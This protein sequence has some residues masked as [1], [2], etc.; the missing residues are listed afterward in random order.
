[1]RTFT[2]LLTACAAAAIAAGCASPAPPTGP[3]TGPT[4]PPAADDGVVRTAD[5]AVH[6]TVTAD[7]RRFQG[8]PYAAPPVGELR[9]RSPQQ[10]RPWGEVRDGTRPGAPCPQAWPGADGTPQASGSEDCLF[11]DV[12][13][14]RTAPRPLPVMVF[15]H[16]G[17]FTG[18][19]GAPYDPTRVVT[20]GDVVVV[21]LNY[22]LGALGFLAHP[23]FEDP[24]TG[25]FGLADQQA[26]LRW[27]QRNI[28]AF[29]GDPANVTL[30]G[31]SAGAFSTCAQL[32]A[33]GARGLFHKAIVQSGPC[34]NPVLA[35]EEA[36]RRAA[37]TAAELGCPGP[38][39][40]VAC[41]RALPAEA[42][43]G[44]YDEQ[45]YRQVHR[46]LAARPWLPVAGTPALP[47]HPVEALRD[48]TAADVPM[49]HGG[50][51]DEARSHVAMAYDMP[52][53]PIT[54]QQ[55]PQVVAALFGADAGA[56]L[57]EYP[58]QQYPAPGVALATAL[59]DEGRTVGACAQQ[60]VVDAAGGRVFAYEFAEPVDEVVG[61]VPMGAHHGADV[62]YFFDSAF[63]GAPPPS[64]TAEEDALATR[65]I[66]YWTAFADTGDPGPD[67][68][69][70]DGTTVL[71][72]DAAGSRPVDLAA[73]HRCAFWRSLPSAG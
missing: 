38:A 71:R 64:R 12:T 65:L 57:A 49:I 22:R 67:W 55:Y 48:G 19:Q 34:A 2:A 11:V 42:F 46:D 5:G 43:A 8:I 58:A 10:P 52:G 47:Q 9:W 28:A 56:V 27:V 70:A 33:P 54:A 26:A 61:T 4:T 16:G 7:T 73:E 41:L 62:R 53:S 35:R 31:E 39:E 36:E 15:V 13:T 20:G 14:P 69:A 18:G 23:G 1:M 44:R 3:T 51:R 6:G 66:G 37:T 24:A 17:G 72:I 50:T 45:V 60:Q 68:P 29:G 21:T 40:A 59:S 25:N 63:P 32:A 30:W